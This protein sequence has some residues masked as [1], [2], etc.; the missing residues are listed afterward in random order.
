MNKTKVVTN[1]GWKFAERCGNS[2]I[3]FIIS[4]VLARILTPE[5]YG[6][7]ALVTVFITILQVFTGSGFGN[8]LI[9]KKN[10]D[11]LDFSTVFYF[12][13]VFS[14][15][16][17][18]T[19]FFV[20]PYIAAFYGDM[21]FIPLIRVLG[22]KV[23]VSGIVNVQSAKTSR[24][25]QFKKFFYATLSGTLLSAVVGIGMAYAGFGVWAL[26]GQTLTVTA[27]NA[28]VLWI[29]VDF[30]PKWIF[31]FERLKS[32]FSY[33][34][35]VLV[36]NIV[37]TLYSNLRTL[38]IG[39]VYS[40]EDLA[41]Y[42]K[43][44][45]FPNLVINNLN[46]SINA[47]LLPTMSQ[48]Q[49]TRERLKNAT[50]KAIRVSSYLIWPCMIG[51]FVC[52]EPL[53]ELL[54]TE[55]WLPCV[56][57]LRMFCITYAFKPIETANVSAIQ[58]VGR[59]DIYLKLQIIKKT[60]GVLSIL[61][62]VRYGVFTIAFAGVLVTPIEA[63][64]NASPNKKLMDY[65]YLEQMKDIIPS[66]LLSVTMGFCVWWFQY[67]SLSNIMILIMQGMVGAGIYILLSMLLKIDSFY[68]VW[69]ILKEILGNVAKK[70]KN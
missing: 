45:S 11:D 36:S 58:A 8:A 63:F 60:I 38:I 64:L 10:A 17:Y 29:I 30:R 26:V 34:W 15:F 68:F 70:R 61:L 37:E 4:I 47:V 16:L 54:L 2:G 7:V 12:Q 27:V 9:Q 19:L 48:I 20:A 67:L 55:K 53:V 33:G 6:T 32:L 42:N 40:T 28:L 35:K 25:M 59:S 65:G 49:D 66:I 5:E 43:G 18:G 41:Y 62:T 57:F 24:S 31:S 51:L 46:T 22:L 13:L 52:A 56:P 39:K 50:R 21:V 14:L 3:N 44:A 1:V 23:V 69:G